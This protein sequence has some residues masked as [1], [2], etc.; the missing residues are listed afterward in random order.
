MKIINPAL[1][2]QLQDINDMIRAVKSPLLI[3]MVGLPGSGKSFIAKQLAEVNDDIAIVSSDAIREEFYG[4]ANDQSHNDKV[5]RIVNKRLKEGLIAEKKVILDATNISKKRRKA[6]LRDLK[7]PKSMAIVMAVPEYICKKRD[8]ERDRH[9]GPDVINKM[10]KN[11]CPPHYSEGFDFISIVYDYDNSA[12]FYNPVLALESAVQINHDNPH[13]SLSIG[14][15]ML[16]AGELI[17][18]EFKAGCPFYLYA[19][20]LLHDIG[21]PY[22]KFY[23]EDGVAHY[24]NH[25]NYGSYLGLF[26]AD[27]MKFS[28][29][30]TLDFINIIYYHMEPL[31]SWKRSEKAHARAIE[32]LGSLYNDIMEVHK[33]DV[34]AH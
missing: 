3:V 13:H 25:Q 2:K 1:W 21:K 18:E 27:Y 14:G 24:Y 8:E 23:D 6:L 33:A 22:V 26:Y 20:A 5:F 30:E 15:H 16:K 34:A 28:L 12:N 17:Q 19:A 11:W 31:L 4:D 7:Y 32:E 29:K 10:I 9:V